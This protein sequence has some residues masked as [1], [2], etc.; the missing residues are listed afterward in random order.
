VTLS[1]QLTVGKR[2]NRVDALEKVTGQAQFANDLRFP[3][4]LYAKVKRSLLG[5]ADIT[6]IDISKAER[7]PGVRAIVTGREFAERFSNPLSGNPLRDQPFLAFDRVRF[8]GEG[9]AVVA[10]ETEEAAE[11]A[12]ELIKVDYQ[13]LPVVLNTEDALREDAVVIHAGLGDYERSPAMNP[14]PGTNICDRIEIIGGDIE[15]GF[16]EA[17]HIFE[18]TFTTQTVQHTA[19]E[20]RVAITRFN[21]D[22]SITIWTSDQAPYGARSNLAGALKIL[23]SKVRIIVPSY[24]GGG[25]GGKIRLTG[26]VCGAAIAWKVGHRPV[27]LLLTR[28]EEFTST[29]TRHAS[30]IILKTGV[31]EDGTFVAGHVKL[32]YDTGAY[33]DRGPT[34]LGKAKYA[35][36]GPYKIP[37]VKVEG[38][39]VYTNKPPAGAFR[40]YGI[41]QVSWA[42][43]QQMDM[44]AEKLGM[45]PIDIRLKNLVDEGYVSGTEKTAH[46]AVGLAECLTRIK[47]Q[48]AVWKKGG[49]HDNPAGVRTGVGV[50]CGY[51][52]SR[53]PSSADAL[54]KLS[55]D[56]GVEIL[57]SSME[58]GQGVNTILCQIA[59]EELNLP[60]KYPGA[61]A[62]YVC[63]SHVSR[64]HLQPHDFF[65]GKC[66]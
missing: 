16:A 40:G 59:A 24:I 62:R 34:V 32:I 53:T 19:M 66:R 52:I 60:R 27:K 31:K 58:M 57:V 6:G 10:A 22:G 8:A 36:F 5:H 21:V 63:D 1:D 7:V 45:D 20:P 37:H 49:G 55:P 11:E 3:G 14:I 12:V 28:E 26:L 43:D 65:H 44:I 54:V 38:L 47:T 18:N 50:A 42:H 41:P 39:L 30:R 46:H 9:V 64:Q 35:A 4:L 56:G 13:E 61:A 29:T 48:M 23:P 51:K 2:E 15:Q 33:A 25:F 17:D